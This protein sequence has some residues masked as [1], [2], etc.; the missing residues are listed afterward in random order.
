MNKDIIAYMISPNARITWG[1]KQAAAA[2]LG[3]VGGKAAALGRLMAYGAPVPPGFVVPPDTDIGASQSQILAAFDQLGTP[4]VAVRSSGVGED[5]P[6]QSWA[7]QF[8]SYL[9]VQ[10]GDILA[11]IADCR[12]SGAAARAQAY[13]AGRSHMPVA[14]I[15]QAMIPSDVSGVLFTANPVTKARDQIVVEAVYG[16][17]ELLVQGIATPDNYL[18]NKTTGQIINQTIVEKTVMLVGATSG[19]REQPVAPDRQTKPALTPVQLAELTQLAGRLE[20]QFGL[21]L[22]LE[23]A[24]AWDKLHI[25]QA[26]PIT[27]L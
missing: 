5:G 6:G 4:S 12:R 21:P 11:R 16:L 17:G 9:Y 10:R 2:P 19:L 15:V 14:V 7:G 3:T 26:R 23:W 27:T 24:Y 25:L 13:D 20:A 22:D 8:E 18:I 1:L